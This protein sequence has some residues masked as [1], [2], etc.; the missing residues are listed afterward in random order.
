DSRHSF[1]W[2]LVRQTAEATIA[3]L[4][5]AWRFFDGVPRRLI[6]DNVPAA[7]AG[8]DPLAPRPTRAFLEYSQARGFLLD[9]ARVRHPKDKPH[10]ER[11]IRYVRERFWKG[12]RF[13]DLGDARRQAQ[14]W[15]MEVAGR[16][17]HGSTGHVPLVV[18]D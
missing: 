10:V 12:G 9:P 4:E 2:P 1:L 7:V 16:R 11:T 18:F 6:L 5:A 14:A 8:P 17:I 15:C 13:T 3:G